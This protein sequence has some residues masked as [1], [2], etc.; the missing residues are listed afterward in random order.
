MN[1]PTRTVVVEIDK[2][3][4]KRAERLLG[5]RG[6]AALLEHLAARPL[7]GDE[8]PGTGGCRKVRWARPGMGKR[9]GA[10]VIHFF[11]ARNRVFVLD[12]Y[13]KNERDD[14]GPAARAELRKAVAF[15]KSAP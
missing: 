14:L 12:V 6:F 13:A 5:E 2:A 11:N 1:G 4:R 3:L 10:R 9:G 7:D 8:I 15:L